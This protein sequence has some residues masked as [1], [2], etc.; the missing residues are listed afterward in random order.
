[1]ALPSVLDEIERLFDELVRRPWGSAVREVV[2]AEV[3]QVENG[4]LM[5]MPVED[6]RATDLK[7]E[8]SGRRVTITGKRR[9][10]SER[11]GQ[12][13]WLRTEQEVSFRRTIL[14][15]AEADPDKIEAKIE[16]ATLVIHIGRRRS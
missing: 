5:Q 10:Q 14:L 9:R 6:M 7:V 2:P 3:Q 4:W 16:G 13:S 1:M 15:P 12:K 8:V 11:Q